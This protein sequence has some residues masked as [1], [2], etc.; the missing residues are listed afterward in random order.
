MATHHFSMGIQSL[1][2]YNSLIISS[3]IGSPNSPYC[4][5]HM[6]DVEHFEIYIDNQ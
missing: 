5:T 1:M 3:I 2:K 6:D 4:D